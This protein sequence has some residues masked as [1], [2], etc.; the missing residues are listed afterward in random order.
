MKKILTLCLLF[1]SA[2]IYA[3]D[4]LF[5]SNEELIE[6]EV[7]STD[8]SE[9]EYTQWKKDNPV[10]NIS[11]SLVD[12]IHYNTGEVEYF[13]N[14]TEPINASDDEDDSD[15]EGLN[16]IDGYTEGLAADIGPVGASSFAGGFCCGLAGVGVVAPI[17]AI[18]NA[19]DKVPIERRL[20][21]RS[22]DRGYVAGVKKQVKRKAWSN[23]AAGIGTFA[24]AYVGIILLSTY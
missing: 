23:F 10:Y 12:S 18:S 21:D 24:A 19:E 13:S 9:I 16:Y 4:T 20:S 17:V 15:T 1:L 2:S 22:Y 3:Q 14:S 6:C 5:L 7:I 11:V 8:E